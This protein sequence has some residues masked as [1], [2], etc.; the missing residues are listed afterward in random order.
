MRP[1]ASRVVDKGEESFNPLKETDRYIAFHI[2]CHSHGDHQLASRGS[3]KSCTIV[4]AD[5]LEY[6][7]YRDC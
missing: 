4:G 7:T 3:T 5:V 6:S 2:L 1:M